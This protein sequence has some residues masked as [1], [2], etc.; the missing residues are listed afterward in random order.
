MELESQI[1]KFKKR[2]LGVAALS[3]D[4][5]EVL[6]DFSTRRGITYPLL[7]DPDSKIIRAFGLLNEADYPKGHMAHGVPFPGTFV[8]D[9]GGVIRIRQFEKEYQER[10]TAA[11]LLVSM[12]EDGAGPAREIVKDQFVLQT[13]VSNPEVAPGRRVTLVLDFLMGPKMHAYAPGV[14]GYR[15]LN[16]RLAENPFVTAH[17]VRYPESRPY[18]FEPLKE[19]VPVFEGHFRVLQDVTALRPNRGPGGTPAPT[20]QMTG[21]DLSGVLEYQVCS[22]TVCYAPSSIPLHW[23]LTVAPL[24]RERAPEALRRKPQP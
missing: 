2:G 8:T 23:T 13:S 9:E 14:K 18:T 10:R 24:D 15:P 20:I 6:K 19:T 5:V 16:F 22:D 3:Y 11:S 12:G 7:S 4:P 21:I 1:E 17:E